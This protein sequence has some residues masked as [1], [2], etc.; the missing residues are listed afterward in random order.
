[1]DWKPL[2]D[3]DDEQGE[4]DQDIVDLTRS[5]PPLSFPADFVD[6]K[7][8]DD[9]DDEQDEDDQEIVDLTG[10]ST[11]PPPAPGS[12]GWKLFDHQLKVA[13]EFAYK[14]DKS[15]KPYKDWIP[16]HGHQRL[17]GFLR[18]GCTPFVWDNFVEGDMAYNRDFLLQLSDKIERNCRGWYLIVLWDEDDDDRWYVY[19]G[20]TTKTNK[21][22]VAHQGHSRDAISKSLLYSV[23]KNAPTSPGDGKPSQPLRSKFFVLAQDESG[24][25]PGR[26]RQLWLNMGEIFFSLVF[27]SFQPQELKFWL[28]EDVA[29]RTPSRGLNVSVPITDWHKDVAAVSS[30]WSSHDPAIRA[31]AAARVTKNLEKAQ[32]TLRKEKHKPLTI[33]LRN[34]PKAKRHADGTL[35]GPDPTKGEPTLVATK[36]KKCGFLSEDNAPVFVAATGAY[37]A[38]LQPCEKCPISESQA[39]RGYKRAIVVFLPVSANL[40]FINEE[41]FRSQLK[42]AKAKA[43]ANSA[44]P[45]KKKPKA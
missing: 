6:W 28:P 7:P 33:A 37:L 24:F 20:Q 2:D 34:N 21:R 5:S 26:D 9:N 13:T 45:L 23:W 12:M 39:Q 1:V 10:P 19:A 43:K 3:G 15:K 22:W 36:C 27:Q 17:F 41:A 44:E 8:L 38:R 16:K 18:K 42:R 11:Y 25:P 32:V 35:R 40:L 31:Y 29:I 30:L 4:D 14:S